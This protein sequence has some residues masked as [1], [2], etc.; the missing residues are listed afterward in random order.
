MQLWHA[1]DKRKQSF[2]LDKERQQREAPTLLDHLKKSREFDH[3]AGPV[4]CFHCESPHVLYVL[5]QLL[6]SPG[7][8]TVSVSMSCR[9]LL[10]WIVFLCV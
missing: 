7:I 4:Q 8:S 5:V 6:K 10:P 3:P 9:K 1:P 2:Y